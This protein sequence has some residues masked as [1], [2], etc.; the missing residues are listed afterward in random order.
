VRLGIKDDVE[1]RGVGYRVKPEGSLLL[2]DE[3]DEVTRA[4]GELKINEGTYK[5]YGQDLVIE[6]GRLVFG[7]GPVSNPGVDVRA[8]RTATDGTIAGILI[9]G[10]A[11]LPVLQL[12]SVPSMS[13]AN[14]LSYIMSG[15]PLDETSGL[16]KGATSALG[17]QGGDAL[18]RSLAGQMGLGDGSVESSVESSGGMQEA[19]LFLGTYL[20]P[21]L[22]M[23]YGIG[24]FEDVRTVRMRYSVASRWSLQAETGKAQSGIIQYRGER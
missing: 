17:V 9:T 24:L 1:I 20:S 5:A 8:S 21:R 14:V 23:A 22:Y 2:I 12:F 18:A 3:P 13:D 19:S 16:G 7:G 6:R 11:L 10:T 4:S 15:K